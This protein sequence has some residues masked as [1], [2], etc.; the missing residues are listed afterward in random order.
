MLID[1][2]NMDTCCP[3]PNQIQYHPTGT[4]I[5]A[6]RVFRP[7]QRRDTPFKTSTVP[8]KPTNATPVTLDDY[9]LHFGSMVNTN[10]MET[11]DDIVPN[12][13][14]K[15]LVTVEPGCGEKETVEDKKVAEL[16]RAQ[17]TS[18]YLHR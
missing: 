3:P 14:P 1:A 5:V 9:S 15:L 12:G 11:H 2:S 18:A 16:P 4:R 13:N 8:F 7:K 10:N 17:V 6:T